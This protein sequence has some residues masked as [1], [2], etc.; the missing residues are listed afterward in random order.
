MEL[1][2]KILNDVR[3]EWFHIVTL[4]CTFCLML[5]LYSCFLKM[6][7]L[8]ITVLCCFNL[9]DREFCYIQLIKM[10]LNEQNQKC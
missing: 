6:L 8:K 7:G 5:V 4:F 1:A 2:L 10:C 3:L 9:D